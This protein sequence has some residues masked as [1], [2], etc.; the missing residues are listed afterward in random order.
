MLSRIAEQED[1]DQYLNKALSDLTKSNA[2]RLKAGLRILMTTDQSTFDRICSTTVR[3]ELTE[4]V[5]ILR[6]PEAVAPKTAATPEGRKAVLDYITDYTLRHLQL[7][8]KR[9]SILPNI[10]TLTKSLL[11]GEHLKSVVHASAL[12]HVVTAAHFLDEVEKKLKEQGYTGKNLDAMLKQATENTARLH[13]FV[14][15]GNYVGV[16]RELHKPG[17]DVNLPNPDGLPLLHVAI[18]EGHIQIV[19]LLLT[20]PDIKVNQLSISGWSPLQLAARLGYTDIVQ[21]LVKQPNININLANSDGWTALHWAAWHGHA[22]MVYILV[23]CPGVQVNPVDKS[24]NTPLH[25]AARNGQADVIAV[26]LATSTVDVNPQDI[27]L[28]TPLHY[29]VAYDHAAATSA[30]LISPQINVNLQDTDGMTPLHWACRNGRVDLTGLLMDVPNL[31]LNIRDHSGLTA[32]D[33]AIRNEYPELIPLLSK[34]SLMTLVLRKLK[35]MF[36]NAID[37]IKCMLSPSS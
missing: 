10:Y 2:V 22:E 24:K 35:Y 4:F 27:D 5:Q 18:R 28:R 17:V 11:S 19:K 7:I 16:E 12:K 6:H 36:Y 25:W 14:I 37:Y 9:V 3:E 8:D 13:N 26:L 15:D 31:K 30:L 1:V 33:W 23:S 32:E 29:A 20:V 21:L 34:S